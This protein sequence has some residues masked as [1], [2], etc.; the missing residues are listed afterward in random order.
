MKQFPGY[1]PKKEEEF[2]TDL[3]DHTDRKKDYGLWIMDY[4]L[5]G[6]DDG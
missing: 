3:T 1:D 4:G 5:W 2:T 6:M